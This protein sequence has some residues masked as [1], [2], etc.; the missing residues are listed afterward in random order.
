MRTNAL[1]PEGKIDLDHRAYFLRGAPPRSP[2]IAAAEDGRMSIVGPD[3]KSVHPIQLSSKIRAVS[4]DPVKRRLAWVDGASGGLI[5]QDF[6][7]SR[8]LEL[9]A[10]F[11][12]CCFEDDGE[13]LWLAAP[14]DAGAVEIR[15]METGS[16]TLL[17]RAIV[18]DPFRGSSA[19]F[20]PTATNGLISLWL[21]AGQDGQQVV[22]LKRTGKSF[23]STLEPKLRNT[24]PPVFSPDG[25]H[26]LVVNEDHALCKFEFPAMES[27]GS[28][29]ASGDEDDPFAESVGHLNDRQ[30]LVGTNE[31]RLF[32]VDTV[33]M[34]IEAEVSLTD[35]Q[36]F[37]RSGTVMLFVS[38]RDKGKDWKDTLLHL[39]V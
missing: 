4:P 2:L 32:V 7:G 21:A 20:H 39:S 37:S 19:S 27:A 16:W 6:E 24:I 17:H 31:Q 28:P 30:A 26:L 11:E 38:R 5:V 25:R 34:T 15:L 22:W 9:P 23:S 10:G 1:K 8:S 12:D 33:E 18:Q 35:I 29:L 14:R 36:Y 3:L 13:F